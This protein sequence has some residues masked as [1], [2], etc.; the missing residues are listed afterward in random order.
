MNLE[1]QIKQTEDAIATVHRNIDNERQA[2]VVQAERRRA[3]LIALDNPTAID[4][5][6][7][8]AAANAAIARGE[9]QLELLKGQK[10]ELE[11]ALQREQ[12][13][14]E[15]RRLQAIHDDVLL[16]LLRD[17][18][19]H[20]PAVAEL[21]RKIVALDAYLQ[22]HGGPSFE[23]TLRHRS[24]EKIPA[25][26]EERWFERDEYGPRMLDGE[27]KEIGTP[28][29][30]R[31]V[32]VKGEVCIRAERILVKGVRL[33]YFSQLHLPRATLDDGRPDDVLE[34]FGD[35]DR[36]DAERRAEE[37]VQQL[38][39]PAAKKSAKVA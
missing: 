16:P 21:A 9:E 4:A 8:T 36:R 6:E 30:P 17:Y 7:K 1:A 14:A 23:S 26:F 13:A 12:E 18:D 32:K 15:K 20:A 2:I 5:E 34:I 31:K 38:L 33:P 29:Q 25:I 37:I 10:A 28:T 19:K 24:E 3:A 22:R 35:R 39:Q 27:G 11:Q